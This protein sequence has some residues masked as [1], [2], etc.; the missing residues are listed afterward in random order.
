MGKYGPVLFHFY[1]PGDLSTPLS[2]GG[3]TTKIPYD[4][5]FSEAKNGEG[6][7]RAVF[8]N[9]SDLNSLAVVGNIAYATQTNTARGDLPGSAMVIVE[10]FVIRSRSTVRG[11]DLLTISGPDLIDELQRF[12]IYRPLGLETIVNTTLVAAASG[13]ITGRTLLVG[14]PKNNDSMSP[15]DSS[16]DD[17]GREVHV[18][19]NSGAVQINLITDHL[20][21]DGRWR[22]KV[23]DRFT[24]SADAGNAIT[25]YERRIRVAA[26]ESFAEG[27]EVSVTTTGGTFTT[28][29]EESPDDDVVTLRDGLPD[30]AVNGA[31]VVSRDYSQKSTS[32]VTQV[33]AYAAGWS[34][35]FETG[36]GTA[37]GTRYGGGGETVYDILRTIAAETG[38]FFRLRSAEA[39]TAGPKRVIKW[40]RTYPA[41]GV[42]GTLRLVEPT[43]A[44]MAAATADVNKAILLERPEHEGVYDP[45]TQVIPIPGDPR[46]S[47]FGCSAA[48]L[49]AAAT[50]GFS[51]VT[52]G[53]GLYAP[54]Y[55]QHDAMQS[56]L[57]THQRRVSFSEV[58]VEGDNAQSLIEAADKLLR[59]S[60][61]LINEHINTAKVIRV[62]CVSDVGVRPGDTVEMYYIPP[63]GE[64]TLDY[65][66]ANVLYVSNVSRTIG[67]DGKLPGV[68]VST[69]E[70]SPTKFVPLS[71]GREVGRRL[72]AVDRALSAL[73]T[74]PPALA[75]TYVGTGGGATPS[76]PP[77][78]G[79]YLPLSG[80]TMTGNIGMGVGLTVDGMDPSAHAADASAHHAPVT[81]V[82]P[83]ALSG[84]E[85]SLA[86]NADAGLYDS[87]GLKIKLASDSGLSLGSNELKLGFA[88]GVS[89]T[90]TNTVA[91]GGHSHAVANTANA[92]TT[93]STLLAGDAEGGLTL[94]RLAVGVA[95]DTAATI[96]ATSK[97][98]DDYTLYLKQKSG[99]TADMWRV[100]NS[101]GSPLVRLTGG[102][103][104]E[105]G[106]PAFVSG[107]TGWR[108]EGATGDAE[109]NNIVA[110]G[111][112]HASI[113]VAD[114]LHASGGT[115][116]ILTASKVVSGTGSNT[117]PGSTGSTFGLNVQA[118]HAD[119]GG[120]YFAVN[121][122]L[123]LKW[124]R[125]NIG[126]DVLDGRDVFLQVTALGTLTG[127]DV[128]NNEPGYYPHTVRWL[129]GGEATYVI[130]N[131][132]AVVKWAEAS[133]S[134][135]GYTGGMTLTTD[136]SY[137]P[138]I[139]IFTIP[140][141][142]Y[143]SWVSAEQ[144]PTARMRIGNLRGVLGKSAD[145]WGMAAGD[146]LSDAATSR[147]YLVASDLGVTLQNIDLSLYN[148]GTKTVELGN[149]GTLK[150]G[151]AVSSGATTSFDFE[152][153]GNL[154]VGPYVAGKPNLKWDGTTLS[155][156]Q[157]AT[158]VIVFDS[159]GA[160]YFAGPM[161]IGASGGIWQGTGTF[162]SPTTGLKLWNSSGVGRLATYSGS[163]TQ[164][165]IDSDGKLRA[166]AGA[167]TLD[168]AGIMV[169]VDSSTA[170]A[171][172]QVKFRGPSGGTTFG[173]LV[174]YA[175]GNDRMLALSNDWWSKSSSMILTVTSSLNQVDLYSGSVRLKVDGQLGDT[176][177][178]SSHF[179][180]PDGGISAGYT[181]SPNSGQLVS[182]IGTSDWNAIV[183]LA[184]PTVAHGMTT[185]ASTNSYG[186]L[187]KNNTDAGGLLVQGLGETIVGLNLAGY[188]TTTS[189][190]EATSSNGAVQ[191]SAFK[192]DGTGT[193]SYGNDDNILAVRNSTST[194]FIVKGDGQ[195]FS[196][197]AHS[198]YDDFA[199]A[200]LVR[201]VTLARSPAGLIRSKFD[202]WVRYNRDDL[203]RLGLL[204]PGGFINVTGMQALHS[205]AI[206][207]LHRR[208]KELEMR[209]GTAD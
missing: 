201:A 67:H 145:E 42:S 69:L 162:S 46:I 80:G 101:S 96:K 169:E 8:V 160:S 183:L 32:D 202:E 109:F 137:S 155:L 141:A 24:G 124:I 40:N 132:T 38:E 63:T 180:L 142:T 136:L 151:S 28:L 140:R 97:A 79:V 150:M 64:Y 29:V 181:F 157:Y 3:V 85:V 194:Q 21:V 178:S 82:A 33:M 105:S 22:Y 209:V 130:P 153:S 81:V 17:I 20:Y 41:A 75:A 5:T 14:A 188:G 23:R 182:D 7:T 61:D 78:T 73:G 62:V 56:A 107:L 26:P 193:T 176:T 123:R 116:A 111:E 94:G 93:F 168:A 106:T 120:S 52:T 170:T 99:Q 115:L 114:E 66:G 71:G 39:A 102:G 135:S 70:L 1:A 77:A 104:L 158:D 2:V 25:I 18:T 95:L 68:P 156:R 204:S 126:G 184:T 9:D 172:T 197:A 16:D 208:I 35:L 154:R 171:A 127:R 185:I 198:T 113:F 205:G 83:I 186:T 167:V 200:E 192:A 133:A 191:L 90:S 206:W 110:R 117:L 139:S 121:D 103:N 60:I 143:S 98:N 4:F 152:T 6:K 108:I 164:I 72:K 159:S 27:T 74:P 161:T 31:A 134:P 37:A 15:T 166:G 51:V 76:A 12:T 47:L 100:E 173:K 30:D 190:T 44:E 48:A 91:G 207:E 11:S 163:A 50:E 118:Q 174:G 203:E 128:A 49:A 125:T 10:P 138:Y 58:S 175:T 54:P 131:G 122:V 199:D 55:V 59:L 19:L 195:I 34:T 45:I 179:H 189:T 147:K 149:T 196:N 88:N 13:P 144:T 177:L 129:R 57:G 86:L 89:A 165:E 187:G 65:T 146:N 36:T 84:Q 53:L 87:S 112:F 119:P 148:A 43:V 92:N